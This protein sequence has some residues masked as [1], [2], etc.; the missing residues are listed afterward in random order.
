MAGVLLL[1][2]CILKYPEA[3]RPAFPK[4]KEKLSDSD[5]SVVSAAVN[6]ICE[7][8][9]KNPK[10]FLSLAPTFYT[11]LVSE[12]LPP[13]HVPGAVPFDRTTHGTWHVKEL[14][15]NGMKLAHTPCD[16]CHVDVSWPSVM[17]DV[18]SVMRC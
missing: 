7:L 10:N 16:V 6:V 18:G 2:K 5:P 4:L 13:P 11:I 1:Y 14:A 9:R 17:L 3:L 12:P 8:A 15:W